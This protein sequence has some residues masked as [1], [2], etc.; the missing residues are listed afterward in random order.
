MKSSNQKVKVLNHILEIVNFQFLIFNFQINK[1]LLLLAMLLSLTSAK[2][3]DALFTNYLNTPM[4][5]NP[6]LLAF[7]NDFKISLSYRGRISKFSQSYNTPALSVVYPLINQE[8]SKRWGGLGFSI[9]SDMSGN[10]EMIKTTGASFAFAYNIQINDLQFVSASLGAG[11]Y[12][13]EINLNSLSTGS[14]YVPNQGFDPNIP[15]NESFT[16]ETKGYLDLLTGVVW[17]LADKQGE[18]KAF[19][20]ISAFHL[21]QPDISMNDQEDFL[22]FRYGLQ[23][24]Y[25]VFSNNKISIF[26]DA[27]LDYQAEVLRYNVGVNIKVPFKGMEQGYLQNA[28]IYF[29]P[30]YV[31]DNLASLGIEFRKTNYIISFTYDFNVSNR[32]VNSNVVDAY[33]VY[34]GFKKNLFKPKQKKEKI[35]VDDQYVVG[36]ERVFNNKEV[37]VLRDTVYLE[38]TA[39]IVE[40]EWTEKLS[41]PE[42]NITFNYKS[43]KVE[44]EAKDLLDE[45][46]AYLNAN[47]DY[48]IEIEGHTDNIGD[49][50]SNKRQSLR[51]A[52]AISNYMIKQ[53]VLPSR[54]RVWG[55][56]ESK[57]IATNATEEGRTKNRRVE[58]KLY[59]IIK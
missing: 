34:I 4:Q 28:S 3:Q 38:D 36:E 5:T 20:G 17:Q 26:P 50:Q 43:D 52:Q 45:I 48:V 10:N 46:I 56:G 15:L 32:S 25:K 23:I 33:E 18:N 11:Y 14:Q 53:G 29:K 24:G 8:K 9:L 49:S 58:F 44:D 47:P 19:A 27:G 41:T 31:S 16:N 40:K 12:R 6:A 55:R 54:I 1:V 7:D 57:P 59:R 51:R 30:R 35:I 2:S 39:K 22:P 37:V 42:R 21:N 13:R